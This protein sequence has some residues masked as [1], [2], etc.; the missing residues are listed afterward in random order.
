V[1]VNRRSLVRVLSSDGSQ[2][3]SKQ[4]LCKPGVQ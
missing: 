1:N 3:A 4:T 2:F